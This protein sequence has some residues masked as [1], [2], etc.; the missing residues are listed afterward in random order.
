MFQNVGGPS[1]GRSLGHVWLSIGV[2]T[3]LRRTM[4]LN[5]MLEQLGTFTG[6]LGLVA[7]ILG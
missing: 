5:C 4:P 7:G 2:E 1:L 6:T 3:M